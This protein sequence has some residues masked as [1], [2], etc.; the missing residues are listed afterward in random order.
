MTL[1]EHE[2]RLALVRRRTREGLRLLVETIQSQQAEGDREVSVVLA[3]NGIA[4]RV[5]R[6]DPVTGQQQ[7]WQ[8]IREDSGPAAM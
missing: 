8:E 1:D 5:Q 7:V 2:A 4:V 3:L 6:V